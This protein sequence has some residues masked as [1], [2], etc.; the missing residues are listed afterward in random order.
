M[1]QAEPG[2]KPG[3]TCWDCGAANWPGASE[4]WLCHRRDWWSRGPSMPSKTGGSR[5]VGRFKL[6]LALVIA[7]GAALIL[8]I[9]MTLD[10]W[11]RN[12][13]GIPILVLPTLAV[14]VGLIVWARLQKR[15]GRSRAM[16]TPEF[17]AAGTTIAAGVI[18]M[19]WL[20]QVIG[21]V[22][23]VAAIVGTLAVPAGLVTWVR[24]QHRSSEGRPM[25]GLQLAASVVF[26][27][28]LL[29]AM[30]VTS[31]VAALFLVCMATGSP[32]FH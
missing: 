24:A 28:I 12:D 25:T 17:V 23:V 30:L 7:G 31:L 18:L 6:P 3:G 10:I 11:R 16:T 4:C 15:A 29:P 26:L 22:K 21:S 13:F 5:D 2:R 20:A 14:P 32:S 19:F 9:G 8:L 27:A 1:S